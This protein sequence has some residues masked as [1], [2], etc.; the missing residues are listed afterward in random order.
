MNEWH[1][2]PVIDVIERNWKPILDMTMWGCKQFPM[3]WNMNKR[4][5][6]LCSIKRQK[7]T[8]EQKCF[9][10]YLILNRLFHGLLKKLIDWS[11]KIWSKPNFG[12]KLQIS[13]IQVLLI[14]RSVTMYVNFSMI[15]HSRSFWWLNLVDACF[16]IIFRRR[17]TSQNPRITSICSKT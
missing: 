11:Q 3:Y 4:I 1:C 2:K 7:I 9:I 14:R 13:Y 16:L 8:I 6:L 5:S 12:K 15:T 10:K 17:L